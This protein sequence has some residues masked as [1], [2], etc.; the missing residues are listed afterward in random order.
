M[1][2]SRAF[3]TLGLALYAAITFS[4]AVCAQA[5]N[6]TELGLFNST[7]GDAPWGAV[8]QGTDGNFY[9]TS[10]FGGAFNG[11][12]IFEIT[13]GGKL[14][15]LYNF[16][17]KA[18]CADGYYPTAAPTLGSDGNFY[19]AVGE[20]GSDAVYESGAGLIYKLSSGGKFTVLYT[21][22][23]VTA[24][25]DGA[26]PTQLVLAS[27][28]SFYGA[29]TVGG[30]FFGGTIF[31]I[32]PTGQ[33]TLLHTFCALENCADGWRPYFPP[34]QG[35]DGNFYG[36]TPIGGNPGSGVFYELTASGTYKVLYNFCQDQTC[37]DGSVPNTITEDANG[38]FFGSSSS[39]GSKG[40]G[41]I[42]EITAG[43]QFIVLHNFDFFHGHPLEQLTLA[44]D[45][46]LYTT[47]QGDAIGTNGGTILKV[48]PTGTVTSL[49]TFGVGNCDGADPSS[50][51]FQ[52]TDGRFY[53]TTVY[54]GAING[55]CGADGTV[56]QFSN[57]LS[58]LVETVPVAGKVGKSVI[59]L[60]NG[61]TGS[62]MVTFNGVPA[63]F[64]VESDTYIKATVPAGATTG[65]VSVVTPSGALNSN[66]QFRVTK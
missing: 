5:Q 50:L 38:N 60:G 8:T 1:K 56:F 27:D 34:I 7:N 16:C 36:T 49:Y 43:N 31:K 33:F 62:S 19:G 11:G 64:T 65:T 18:K 55:R 26:G 21:F 61:L 59:I 47:T 51:L 3:L 32:S 24:C 10:A 14:R 25:L 58:P 2:N 48:T 53:G 40:Y 57:G 54:G 66:P 44:N 42:F 20:G 23:T 52:G 6:L 15:D 28:G 22:C 17:S 45:G 37:S 39:G 13:S 30:E 9:G 41:D 46:N 35:N 29:T 4:L 12:T 63:S